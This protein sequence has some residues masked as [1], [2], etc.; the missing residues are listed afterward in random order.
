MGLGNYYA[1]KMALIGRWLWRFLGEIKVVVVLCFQ[2]QVLFAS[3]LKDVKVVA[4][5]TR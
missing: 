4:R 2:M 1:R 3:C 5:M